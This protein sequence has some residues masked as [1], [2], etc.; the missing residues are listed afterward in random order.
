M[1]RNITLFHYCSLD[2]FVAVA[3][4]VAAGVVVVVVADRDLTIAVV[5]HFHSPRLSVNNLDPEDF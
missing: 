4:A 1:Q 2:S 3:G 5:Q